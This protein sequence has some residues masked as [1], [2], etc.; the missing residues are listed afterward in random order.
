MKT[1][2]LGIVVN[3][4]KSTVDVSDSTACMVGKSLF[5]SALVTMVS[6][7]PKVVNVGTIVASKG[8]EGAPMVVISAKNTVGV[9]IIVP[10]GTGGAGVVPKSSVL[11]TG[12]A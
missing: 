12:S 10:N 8:P 7:G 9:A 4:T 3:V 1:T 6:T 5:A 11:D 2:L